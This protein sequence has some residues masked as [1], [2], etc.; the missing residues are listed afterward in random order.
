LGGRGAGH[1]LLHHGA[2]GRVLVF[3]DRG[4]F[5]GGLDI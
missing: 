4:M 3:G 2:F 5:E 1:G